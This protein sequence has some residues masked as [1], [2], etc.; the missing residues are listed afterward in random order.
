M[1]SRQWKGIARRLE[2]SS[3]RKGAGQ[4]NIGG[5]D[6][7]PLLLQNFRTARKRPCDNTGCSLKT[8]GAPFG[9]LIRHLLLYP[10]IVTE[11]GCVF[12]TRRIS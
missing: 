8:S 3:L 6:F 7:V 4:W 9:D 1:N 2:G 12:A 5:K 11:S 10:V